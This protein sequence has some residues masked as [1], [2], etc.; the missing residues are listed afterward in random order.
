M[1]RTGAERAHIEVE[2]AKLAYDAR[3]RFIADANHTERRDYLLAPETAV[4]LAALVDPNR[5]MAAATPLTESVHKDTV[6]VTV[7]DKDRWLYR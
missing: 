6:Y 3:T 5:A 1:D 7:V 2:V 4:K